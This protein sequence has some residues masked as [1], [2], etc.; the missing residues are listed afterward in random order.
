MPFSSLGLSVP[1]LRAASQYSTPTPVQA[2]AI[3]VVLTGGDVLATARTGS[4]KTTAFVL[5]LLQLWHE[6]R[7]E[8][9]RR[10]HTL[11]L[12]PTRELAAQV[13]DVVQDCASH[14]P[15]RVKVVSAVGGVS[16]NPQMMALRGGADFLIATPGRLL[17]L[18]DRNALKLSSVAALVLDEADRM[19]D[20]GFSVELSRILMLL[21]K[22]CQK[23]LF[24]ATFPTAVESIAAEILHEPTR[25]RID[26]DFTEPPDIEQRAIR[27]DTAKRTPLLRHLLTTE[28]WPRVLVFVARQYAADHVAEKLR[29]YGIAA[30][31]FHGDLSQ[32]ARGK[33]LADF[34]NSA[35]RV[36][37]ATDLAARGLDI[38]QLPAVVNYDLPR[39][40]TDYI[41]RIGRTGRAG[42]P[43]IAVSF[44]T[45]ESDPHFALIEKRNGLRIPR[46]Q[47]PGFEPTDQVPQPSPGTGGIKGRRKS[48]KDK[49]REA[50]A[51]EQRRKI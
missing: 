40:A 41:H 34:K 22:Q 42:E 6:T 5:P 46:E 4:G 16:I 17:D 38:V 35:I 48:K 49:L 19:L 51:K 20:L 2:A 28:N 18:V 9:P 43:G 36:L 45:A 14:L 12:V 44:I 24:S 37:V 31:S 50:A 10:L 7:H 11:I 8:P 29:P 32:E 13:R 21:P 15:E 3:P 26:P 30:H 33:V 47:I 1:L 25:I 39:S 23:L 27:V